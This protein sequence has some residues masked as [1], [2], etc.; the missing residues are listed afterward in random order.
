VVFVLVNLALI[1]LRLNE[2]VVPPGA[3]V[4]PLA[5]PILGLLTSALMIVS[6]LL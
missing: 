1:R 3:L 6:A 4:V 5:L 2:P